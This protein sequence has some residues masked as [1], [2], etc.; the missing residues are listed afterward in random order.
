MEITAAAA[1]SSTAPPRRHWAP[2]QGSCSQK[3]AN[4]EDGASR[5][6]GQA[7][8]EKSGPPSRPSEIQ[9]TEAAVMPR[10]AATSRNWR[11]LRTR[12]SGIQRKLTMRTESQTT[13]AAKQPAIKVR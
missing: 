3:S 4:Q 7:A 5:R 12:S 13:A 1:T 10:I 11:V 2:G 9:P 8:I 6:P